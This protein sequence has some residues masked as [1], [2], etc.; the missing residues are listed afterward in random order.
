VKKVIAL[1]LGITSGYCVMPLDASEITAVGTLRYE[2][3]AGFEAD[4]MRIV[5]DTLPS[6]YVVEAPLLSY[7]GKLADDLK[8]VVAA[9]RRVLRQ[10]GMWIEPSDWKANPAALPKEMRGRSQHERD[11]YRICRWW[12]KTTRRS[13]N[14]E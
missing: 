9:T 13:L 6:F 11:A 1:D 5:L 4:L 12:L 10:G 3:S 14:V 2:T 7:R 8:E